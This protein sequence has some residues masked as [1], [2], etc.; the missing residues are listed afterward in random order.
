MKL[1]V[2]NII[3]N[4]FIYRYTDDNH[5][6]SCDRC[7]ITISDLKDN[8]FLCKQNC[9]H[10]SKIIRDKSLYFIFCFDKHKVKK[11]ASLFA[12]HLIDI[13]LTGITITKHNKDLHDNLKDISIHNTRNI[14]A[15]IN[16]K[17]LS[18]FD[19]NI[20][21][22]VN[23]KIKYIESQILLRPDVIARELLSIIKSINQVMSEYNIIDLLKPG[24]KL[25]KNE[26][27]YHKVHTLC[28]LTFYMYE[29]EIHKNNLTIYIDKSDECCYVNF[30][31]IKT[32]LAQLYE[33][34]I[35][36]CKPSTRIRIHFSNYNSSYISISLEMTS[37]YFSN[38]EKSSLLMP[39]IRG[40]L[41]DQL[42]FDGKGYG[43]SIIN[44]MTELNYGKFNFNSNNSTVHISNGVQYSN[45]IF[46]ISL[47]KNEN[48]YF[49]IQNGH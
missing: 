39:E 24:C 42:N 45:N 13:Y 19:E 27:G 1:S 18:M 36:Y 3:N 33:N 9:Y 4:S 29:H 10:I 46:S 25:H 44:R 32:A 31:T 20:L 15:E 40:K 48:A 35:K 49:N 28:A 23:N 22:E 34:A 17:L 7:F 14:N 12:K 8:S 21:S 38:E 47:L 30:G 6:T 41:A 37:L 11:Q 43:M 16:S 5:Q 2:Y 26:F